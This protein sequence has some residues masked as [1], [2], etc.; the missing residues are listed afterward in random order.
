MDFFV[1]SN[2]SMRLVEQPSLKNLIEFL[3][4]AIKLISRRTLRRD[5]EDQ[6]KIQRNIFKTDLYKHTSTSRRLSLAT[7]AWSVRNY[8]D[9]AAIT[10]H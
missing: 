10:V 9:H 2:L 8:Q 3:N 7:D 4:P 5:L 6:F 1:S